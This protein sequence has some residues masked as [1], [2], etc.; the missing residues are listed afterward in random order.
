MKKHLTLIG[1]FLLYGVFTQAQI[2]YEFDPGDTYGDGTKNMIGQREYKWNNNTLQWDNKDSFDLHYNPLDLLILSNY[3]VP[4]TATPGSWK[5]TSVNTIEHN[6]NQQMTLYVDTYTTGLY[7]Q[8]FEFT[9]NA[10]GD[11]IM[12]L[13][14]QR[15]QQTPTWNNYLRHS[16]T[17]N[18]SNK[19]T[20]YLSEAWNSVA[21]TWVNLQRSL[22]TYTPGNLDSTDTYE[23][24]NASTSQWVKINRSTYAYDANANRTLL[25]H[26]KYDTAIAS[27]RNDYKYDYTYNGSN[28]Q[29]SKVESTWNTNTNTWRNVWRNTYTY[30]AQALLVTNITEK[31]NVNTLQ[32]D[33]F[34]IQTNTYDA[35]NRLISYNDKN[36]VGNAW[37]EGILTT[38]SRNANGYRTNYL[39]Q[40][41]NTNT[42]AWKNFTSID[43][44]YDDKT[45]SGIEEMKQ[46]EL[47][48]FPNPTNAPTV[49]VNADAAMPYTIYD[50]TGRVVEQG[51]LQTGTNTINFNEPKGVYLLKAGNAT[52][53]IVKQ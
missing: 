25:L 7:G 49:F 50:L 5:P 18:A 42:L 28:Q 34:S 31:W 16:T 53:R 38:Y 13:N 24:W 6:A 19:I 1:A 30:N 23:K 4:D 12:K 17:Y 11:E 51:N 48:V 21:S 47:F 46:N 32:W 14:K 22:Y 8:I 35:N 20:V 33:S 45:I 3:N 26:Q 10:N 41:W 43:Y 2:N 37:E 27:Y 39:L 44:W 15:T 36:R 9:Y 40:F 52:T 29:A